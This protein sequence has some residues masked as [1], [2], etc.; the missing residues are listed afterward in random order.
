LTCEFGEHRPADLGRIGNTVLQ[1]AGL[2]HQETRLPVFT[3]V[4][5]V[6]VGIDH[7]EIAARVQLCGY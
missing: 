7:G 1:E 5:I 3:A 6:A 2:R 4:L